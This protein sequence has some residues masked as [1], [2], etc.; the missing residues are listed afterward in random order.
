MPT[1]SWS[2]LN[3]RKASSLRNLSWESCCEQGPVLL[4]LLPDPSEYLK[5]LFIRTDAQVRQFRHSLRQYNVVFAF[6]SL[7]CDILSAEKYI[8]SAMAI[9]KQKCPSQLHSKAYLH[10]QDLIFQCLKKYL[11]DWWLKTKNI[12]KHQH[13]ISKKNQTIWRDY[14]LFSLYHH[15][16]GDS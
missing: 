8:F 11:S 12:K 4:Q 7:E 2:E 5:D 15:W 13:K 3:R 1:L 9:Q 6:T 10:L 14:Y 16:N